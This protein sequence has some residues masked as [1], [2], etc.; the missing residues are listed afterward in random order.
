MAD[1]I[2]TPDPLNVPTVGA[3]PFWLPDTR[4]FLAVSIVVM[5]FIIVLTLMWHPIS[6]DERVSNLLSGILGILIA[7]FKDVYSFSFN[8]TQASED[9]SKTIASLGD[10][11]GKSVPV[12]KV[13]L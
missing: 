10:T 13:S 6:M 3:R 8:S 5:M 1:E 12:D 11:L 7:T 9:K 2:I 4:G